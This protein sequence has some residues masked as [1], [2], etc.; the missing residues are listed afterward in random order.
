GWSRRRWRSAK[1]E[2]AWA[3]SDDRGGRPR[4]RFPP[5]TVLI[6]L[7]RRQPRLQRDARQRG[8]QGT[9]TS[10]VPPRGRGRRSAETPLPRWV[11]QPPSVPDAYKATDSVGHAVVSSRRATDRKLITKAAGTFHWTASYPALNCRA[12]RE[13]T[14]RM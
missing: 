12:G 10:R 11:A 14:L 5:R 4:A 6:A 3:S 8:S 2:S 9:T 7:S 13:S 1:R